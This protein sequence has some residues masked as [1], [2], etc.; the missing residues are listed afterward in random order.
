MAKKTGTIYQRIERKLD[1]LESKA[2]KKAEEAAKRQRITEMV[3][4]MDFWE[5]LELVIK[6]FS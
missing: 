5:R 2:V 6:I 1:I 3:R 4:G